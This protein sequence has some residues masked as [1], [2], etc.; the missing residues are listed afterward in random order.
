MK[1]LSFST[2]SLNPL[3]ERVEKLTTLHRILIY[4]GTYLLLFVV[5][6]F[7]FYQPKQERIGVLESDIETLDR[8]LEVA[9]RNAAQL[10]KLRAAMKKEEERFAQLKK[11]L[12]D[13]KEIPT[14]LANISQAGNHA[15]LEFIEFRPEPEIPKD[16]YKEIPVFI[17]VNGN[18]HNVGVFYDRVAA[19][20]RIVTIRNISMKPSGNSDA[21]MLRTSCTAV[22]YQFVEQPKGK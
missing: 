8:K 19:L 4:V 12:P 10:P 17:S 20:S 11:A 1:K 9:R 3:M 2:D 18:Y 13:T 21:G 16:F 7:V 14:L 5:A 6:Y 22:T 15:G